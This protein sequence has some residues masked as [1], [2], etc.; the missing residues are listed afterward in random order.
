MKTK[1]G[2][3]DRE[4]VSAMPGGKNIGEE[5]KKKKGGEEGDNR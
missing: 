3:I 4:R 1:E 2:A 5:I